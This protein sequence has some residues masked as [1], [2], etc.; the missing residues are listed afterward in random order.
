M[1]LPG[2]LSLPIRGCNL[3]FASRSSVAIQITPM[4]DYAALD[5]FRDSL[6]G[7]KKAPSGA[8]YMDYKHLATIDDKTLQI[9]ID[10]GWVKATRLSDPFKSETES[11][12]GGDTREYEIEIF[13]GT[14]WNRRWVAHAHREKGQ[15]WNKTSVNHLKH[16]EQRKLKVAT[17]IT[18]STDTMGKVRDLARDTNT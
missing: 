16:W 11:A 4:H 9:L 5:R 1:P 15:A 10:H 2:R 18:I 12:E 17:R 6:L 14:R 13:D 7:Q 8:T 3:L